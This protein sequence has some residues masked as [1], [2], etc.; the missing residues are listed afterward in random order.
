MARAESFERGDE[1]LSRLPGSP[2]MTVLAVEG[3]KVRCSDEENRQHWF[4]TSG[5]DA[6]S[7]SLPEAD[8]R[9]LSTGRQS[10][11]TFGF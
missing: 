7:G 4:D 5:H 10:F 11:A 1:V 3:M 9:V 6:L 2:I 8:W